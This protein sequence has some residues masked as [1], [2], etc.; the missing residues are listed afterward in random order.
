MEKKLIRI[1]KD[2]ERD[3]RE[4]REMREASRPDVVRV[5]RSTAGSAHIREEACISVKRIW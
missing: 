5:V 4:A 1:P 3:R 2:P